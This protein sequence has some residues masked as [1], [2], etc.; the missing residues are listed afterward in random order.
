MLFWPT[1]SGFWTFFFCRFFAGE[2]VEG[3]FR[4]IS[5]F[6]WSWSLDNESDFWLVELE[7]IELNSISP[8]GWR[9]ECWLT[10]SMSNS[11]SLIGE[12]FK[13][14][15]DFLRKQNLEN[16][17]FHRDF[18]YRRWK[19]SFFSQT[20]TDSIGISTGFSSTGS[21]SITI[22]IGVNGLLKQIDLPGK[23]FRLELTLKV[24]T[25]PLFS[26]PLMDFHNVH[27]SFELSVNE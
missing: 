26:N 18:I 15:C 7:W 19:R 14:R 27:F 10:S 17:K 5:T 22:G 8:N 1:L 11:F 6:S 23:P 16:R 24:E 3:D 4:L 2:L 9:F 25:M 21:G 13:Q 20:K 12:R